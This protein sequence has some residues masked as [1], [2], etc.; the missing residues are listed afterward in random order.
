MTW[1][2]ENF[3][4]FIVGENVEVWDVV[5]MQNVV[6]WVLVACVEGE[7]EMERKR[8]Q[9]VRRNTDMCLRD[10]LKLLYVMKGLINTYT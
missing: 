7:R 4:F 5:I 2:G 6:R 1:A 9:R 10:L 8:R 3:T